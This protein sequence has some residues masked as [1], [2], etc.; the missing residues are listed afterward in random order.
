MAKNILIT[1]EESKKISL[2]IIEKIQYVLDNFGPREPGSESE[3]KTQKYLAEELDENATSV[4]I[5][6][7]PVAPIGLLFFLPLTGIIVFFSSFAINLHPYLGLAGIFT[8]LLIVWFQFGQYRRLLDP[9]LP[10]KESNNVFARWIPSGKS[11]K[12]RI[13]LCG[14]ADSAYEMRFNQWGKIYIKLAA[15]ILIISMV[16]LLV[17]S[18]L[19]SYEH[20]RGQELLFIPEIIRKLSIVPGALYGA[21]AVYFIRF[22]YVVP[23]ANDNLSGSCL[24]IEVLK[25][26][27]KH[28]LEIQ[29]TEIDCLITGS[30]EAGLRGAMAFV[31][32]HKDELQSIPTVVIAVDTISDLIDMGVAVRDLNGLLPHHPG[33]ISL[34]YQAG[35]E[36]GVKLKNMSVYLGSS[37]ATVFTRNHTPATAFVAMDPSPARYYHTRYDTIDAMSEEALSTGLTILIQTVKNYDTYGLPENGLSP[38]L[39]KEQSLEKSAEKLA[40]G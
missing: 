13:I 19:L 30:E 31:E 1:K 32:Q 16:Y 39:Q 26:F 17:I 5:E 20:F 37:D 2:Q 12:Q 10:K 34:L 4:S 3:Y 9:F 36:C 29:N 23:G 38:V 25:W 28:P 8:S 7:F 6:P 21:I 27:S 22:S 33:V 14:H 15:V 24:A 11:I 40:A 18:L 35:L